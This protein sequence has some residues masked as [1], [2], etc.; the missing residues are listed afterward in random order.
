MSTRQSLPQPDN[1]VPDIFVYRMAMTRLVLNI[2]ASNLNELMP[3]MG[4]VTTLAFQAICGNVGGGMPESSSPL[5]YIIRNLS[6]PCE[7][8]G[9]KAMT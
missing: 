2:G 7:P 5:A 3:K 9:T 4:Y 1:H 6:A 8:M